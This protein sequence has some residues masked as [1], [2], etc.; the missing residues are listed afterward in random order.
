MWMPELLAPAGSMESLEAAVRFGADAVYGGMKRYGLRAFAGNFDEAQLREA[1]ALCHRAGRRF[2]LT[3]NI[4]P[5]D[6]QLEGLV[7]AAR[8]A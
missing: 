4:F 6:D 3:L 8:A 1:V 5:F 2:Y 7:D